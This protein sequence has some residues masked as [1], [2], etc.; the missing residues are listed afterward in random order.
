MWGERS[1]S[2]HN[3]GF[4]QG[5]GLR[6]SFWRTTMGNRRS[7]TRWFVADS[8]GLGWQRVSLVSLLVVGLTWALSA[9]RVAHG[10]EFR[11]VV[12][13][14]P[15]SSA[16]WLPGEVVIHTGTDLTGGLTFFLVNPT[17]RTHVFLVEGL[18]EQVVGENGEMSA[19]PLRVT[20]GP[21]DSVRTLVSIAQWQGSRERGA[22]E[23]FR[24]FCP[25]H[26]GDADSGGTI[27][28]V[29]LGGTI[30]TVP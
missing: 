16:A 24:F 5:M 13:D 7:R 6:G 8:R 1:M 10:S 22:V 4:E 29:H 3:N 14:L 26:K 12:E 11:F 18:Y 20:V 21:E 9:H 17:A 27:R 30:R 19:K 25:L 28:M 2:Y 15:D 23:T